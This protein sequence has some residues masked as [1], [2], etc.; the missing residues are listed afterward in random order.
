MIVVEPLDDRGDEIGEGLVGSLDVEPIHSVQGLDLDVVDIAPRAL[1]V[2]GFGL[3][4][5]P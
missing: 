5:L 4:W 1:A 3:E 2:D